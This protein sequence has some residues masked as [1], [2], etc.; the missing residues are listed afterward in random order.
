MKTCVNGKAHV[1]SKENC[2]AT[3]A[4]QSVAT[5][6]CGWTQR[7]QIFQFFKKSQSPRFLCKVFLR[8]QTKYE[9]IFS[10]GTCCL[11]ASLISGAWLYLHLCPSQTDSVTVSEKTDLYGLS[12]PSLFI[13]REAVPRERQGRKQGVQQPPPRPQS[14]PRGVPTALPCLR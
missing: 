1:P 9:A 7:C 6:E 4:G 3:G 12:K 10:A 13:S 2:D 8:D 14:L 11:N 5:R